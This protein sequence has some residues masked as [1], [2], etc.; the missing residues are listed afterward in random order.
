L[1][2]ATVPALLISPSVVSAPVALGLTVFTWQ[3]QCSIVPRTKIR[4][5]LA[6]VLAL[7]Q[8]ALW[9]WFITAAVTGTWGRRY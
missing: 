3:K 7:I 8:I 9:V 6:G 2:A 1:F 4:F 5:I